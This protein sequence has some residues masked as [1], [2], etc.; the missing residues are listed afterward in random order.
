MSTREI[1]RKEWGEYFNNLSR[2]FKG[3]PVI[4]EVY[5]TEI[6][7][8]FQARELPME[9]VI[10]DLKVEGKNQIAILIEESPQK[11][12]VHTI[13]HPLH[14]RVEGENGGRERSM[15]IESEDGLTTLIRFSNQQAQKTIIK[16]IL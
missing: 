16:G 6:G 5:G 13:L 2:N 7:A 1:P 15:Q 3:W 12:L 14:V 9:G 4:M 8:Q 10:A 11:H